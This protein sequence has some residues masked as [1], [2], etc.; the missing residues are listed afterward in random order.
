MHPV[1][2]RIPTPGWSLPL[3][4]TLGAVPIF[5]YGVMLGL[6]LVVGWYLTL[7][8]CERDGLDR[9]QM[10]SCYVVT[11]ILAVLGSRLLF[12][13]TNP[14]Q[15]HGLSDLFALRG[16]GL[17]AYGG[18][19]GGFV[20]SW[21][22]LKAKGKRLLP[23]A[24]AAVPSLASG[25]AITRIG[26]YLFGCDY[27]RR[28]SPEA[29]RWLANLGTFPRWGDASA[30]DAAGSPAW[31]EHV[32]RGLIAPSA[33]ASLPVH[34]T[35][36]YEALCGGLLLA[37]LL[38]VRKRRRFRGQ[39]FCVATVTYGAA[40]FALELL[41]DDPERGSIA[42]GAPNHLLLPACFGLLAVCC[43]VA[44]FA[45]V[46]AALVRRSL[47]A[48]GFVPAIGAAVWLR[49]PPFALPE[50]ATLSTSQLIGLASAA[51]ATALFWVG[52]RAAKANPAAA[53]SLELTL[54][55]SVTEDPRDTTG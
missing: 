25:L 33:N 26:C 44:V 53:M 2:F 48:L 24:D 36:L 17:V 50:R 23:W 15:F 3:I 41:R 6:S 10:G 43:A 35:Q 39:V 12:L 51:A 21:A 38:A 47:Q 8:L 29:P 27:G 9:E 45:D 16:G 49:P 52:A 32:S 34:P 18:F 11:A 46:E 20:G 14:D 54:T 30:A 55:A 5:S 4:G 28:L 7:G 37:L 19:L 42:F 1:L 40:R 31:A 13:V 22:F